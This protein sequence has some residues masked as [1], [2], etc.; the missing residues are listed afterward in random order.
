MATNEILESY[1]RNIAY[2]NNASL[3]SHYQGE[4]FEENIHVAEKAFSLRGAKVRRV[5]IIGGAGYVGSVLTEHLLD[6][7]YIVRSFDNLIY[8][9]GQTVVPF[10]HRNSYEFLR[11]DITVKSDVEEALRDVDDVILLAGLV[12]DPITKKYPAAAEEI[13]DTGYDLVL[14]LLNERSLNKVVFVSTCSNYG[15]IEGNHLADED[16]A[17]NP[18][19]LYAKSKVQVEKKILNSQGSVDYCPTILRFATAFGLSLRMRFDLTVSEFTRAMMLGHD[20]RVYDAHTWRPYCHLRDFSELIRRVIEA[21]RERVNFEVFNAGGDVNNFT[22]QMLVDAIIEQLP[23]GKYAH[24]DS[25]S[26]ARNYRVDFS[27]VRS[28]LFFEPSYTISDGIRELIGAMR[29]G[30]F[31]NFG[32]HLNFYGNWEIRDA[33]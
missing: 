9:H 18:L 6:A 25:G 24:Q 11:G 28:R 4:V 33:K 15:L 30:L 29:Q 27:K 3:P 22:K 13:N 1:C 21:P 16:F 7:G 14:H 2:V 31:Q 12:G 32:E 8:N 5:L 10:L 23:D 19:S 20:L 26:D 17:L